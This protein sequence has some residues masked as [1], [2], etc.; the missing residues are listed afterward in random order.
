MSFAE[1]PHC[2]HF[3]TSYRGGHL[4]HDLITQDFLR[5]VQHGIV[6]MGLTDALVYAHDHH[7]RKFENF[8]KFLGLHERENPLHDGNHSGPCSRTPVNVPDK[9]HSHGPKSEISSAACQGQ[10]SA[11]P[12]CLYR[13]TRKRQ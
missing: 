13:N 7:R 11:S 5:S 12:Q 4:F 3:G 2:P 6:A 1:Q 8:W 9:T 10:I